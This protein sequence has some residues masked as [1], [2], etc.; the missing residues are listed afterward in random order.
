MLDEQYKRTEL[1]I[2][3]TNKG[4]TFNN[5]VEN[6]RKCTP[7]KYVDPDGRRPGATRSVCTNNNRYVLHPS[8]L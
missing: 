4:L 1:K 6:E 8:S 3:Y 5:S 7:V 2:S